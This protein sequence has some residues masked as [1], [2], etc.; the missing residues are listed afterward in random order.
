MKQMAL[1]QLRCAKHYMRRIFPVQN[2]SIN[3]D[4]HFDWRRLQLPILYRNLAMVIE[5]VYRARCV[6]IKQK[7]NALLSERSPPPPHL[8]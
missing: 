8:P 3:D 5:A 4:S 1:C 6:I 7:I 2:P